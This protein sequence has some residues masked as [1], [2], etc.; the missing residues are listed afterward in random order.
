MPPPR[1][2]AYRPETVLAEK[3]HAMVVLGS[4]NSR[5]RD[6]FDLYVLVSRRPFQAAPVQRA[7]EAT[8]LRR[9]TSIPGDPPLALTPGFLRGGDK[10]REWRAFL[11][12]T[13]VD[14]PGS[15]SNVI[16]L[17]RAFFV[18]VLQRASEQREPLDEDWPPGGPWS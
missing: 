12:R 8:F 9:D 18:P 1:V 7:I 15:M 4:I 14:A 6:F 11:S 10:E 5:M 16:S 17:L 2:R 13:G 3:L